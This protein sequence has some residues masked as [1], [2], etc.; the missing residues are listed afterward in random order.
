[1]D[2]NA[3]KGQDQEFLPVIFMWKPNQYLVIQT[4]NVSKNQKK[5]TA[6]KMGKHAELFLFLF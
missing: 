5:V 4:K 6:K 1:V 3:T 2:A